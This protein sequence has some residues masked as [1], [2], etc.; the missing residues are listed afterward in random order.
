MDIVLTL[1][2]GFSEY[3]FADNLVFLA[4]KNGVIKGENP[5]PGFRL[6]ECF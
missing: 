5:T 3:F 2:L 1:Q 6:F 4:L